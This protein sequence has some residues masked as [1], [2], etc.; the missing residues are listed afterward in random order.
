MIKRKQPEFLLNATGVILSLIFF[1]IGFFVLLIAS[2]IYLA[3]WMCYN[4]GYPKPIC[5]IIAFIFTPIFIPL[6]ILSFIYEAISGDDKYS[7]SSRNPEK[8]VISSKKTRDHGEPRESKK[9]RE[10]AGPQ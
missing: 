3:D 9:P 5:Y 8:R 2:F 6:V 4:T 7:L 1:P 10:T